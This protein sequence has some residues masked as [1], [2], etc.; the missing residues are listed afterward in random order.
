WITPQLRAWN[1]ISVFIAFF[2]LVAVALLL[3]R[4]RRRV[5]PSPGRRLL[6]GSLLAGVLVIGVLDQTT[7]QDV[8]AYRANAAP[9]HR[10][11]DLVA[12]IERRLPRGAMVFQLPYMGFPEAKPTHRL[13]TH[14]QVRGSA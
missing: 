3:D 6:F 14:D 13:T 8:P 12:A 10:D 9:F 2:S 5:G 7:P 4:L 11:G 1:R